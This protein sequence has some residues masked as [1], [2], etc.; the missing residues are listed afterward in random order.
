VQR[1]EQEKNSSKDLAGLSF[2]LSPRSFFSLLVAKG[3]LTE[4][5]KRLRPQRM[6]VMPCCLRHARL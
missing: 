1:T 6:L 2:L 4:V 3:Y 5:K